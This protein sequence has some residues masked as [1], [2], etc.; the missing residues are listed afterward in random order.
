MTRRL[1]MAISV[2]AVG[3]AW[4]LTLPPPPVSLS[5]AGSGADPVRGV[6]HVHTRRSDGTGTVDDVARAAAEAGLDFVI[7]TDHGDATRE[8]DRPTYRSGVLCI[9]AVEI[10]TSGGHVVALGLGKAPYPLAG[11]AR[12]VIDDIARLGGMSI[13]AHPDSNK[14]ELRWTDWSASFDG[15]EWLNGDSEW[16]DES[17]RMLA[18]VLLAFPGRQSSALALLLDRPDETLR[19]W[20]DLTQRRR[21][22]AVAGSD[23]HARLGLRTL[24]EP[25]D[26]ASL[27]L[28]G[29]AQVFRTFS[30]TL[31][32]LTLRGN[33]VDDAAAVL[34][35]IR[36]GHLYS[37]IDAVAT[38]AQLSFSASGTDSSA[39][40]GDEIR[41]HGPVTVRAATNA[42]GSDEIRLMRNGE[43]MASTRGAVL[44]QTVPPTPAVY[45]VEVNFPGAPGEPPIP[46]IVSNPIYVRASR[47]T[48]VTPARSSAARVAVRYD[49]GPAT[50]W[51]FEKSERASAAL[52]VIGAVDGT[53]LLMRYALGGS[54]AESPFV[55]FVMPAGSELATYDRLM[56]NVR[57]DHP[58]RLSVQVRVPQGPA[59]ERWQR[60][61]YVDDTPRTLTVFFDDMTAAGTTTSPRPPLDRVESVLFVV[62]SVNTKPG[63]SG[64]V[65]IDDVKYAR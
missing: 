11:E 28:P 20:D 30:I 50:G 42:P 21:V 47:E 64:Q 23:A 3:A 39:M 43:V 32:Q 14:P 17:P 6:I 16:R 10:S 51:R 24:G 13:S 46:W 58:M 62:D 29:Y 41:P 4:Y 60:S 36:A 27:P 57:A 15:L 5:A 37:T 54:V 53:Q 22:T 18:R 34:A 25:Y 61:V 55:A 19:R 12:D 8:P 49:N 26:R 7:L 63:T 56:F 1:T 38:P 52:D 31:P 9:D 45:R 2:V 59:G 65:W 35:E 33:P 44:E 40:A 48:P